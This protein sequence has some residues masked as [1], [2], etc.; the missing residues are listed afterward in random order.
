MPNRRRF[1]TTSQQTNLQF[2]MNNG[3]DQRK[4]SLSYSLSL[5]VNMLLWLL[6]GMANHLAV[7]APKG[8]KSFVQFYVP[9]KQQEMV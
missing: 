9:C 3:K 1:K 6:C 5:S 2:T 7:A 8:N 4:M